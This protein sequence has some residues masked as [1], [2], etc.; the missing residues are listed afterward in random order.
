AGER[1]VLLPG[2]AGVGVGLIAAGVWEGAA[3]AGAAVG[4]GASPV[5]SAGAAAVLSAGA[6]VVLSTVASVVGWV[7]PSTSE[8][9]AEKERLQDKIKVQSIALE[10][11]C[12]M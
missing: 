8:A 5:P 6:A 4:E 9:R 2:M 10:S 7:C 1:G 11:Q 3:S 12:R